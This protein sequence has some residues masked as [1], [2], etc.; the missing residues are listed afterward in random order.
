MNGKKLRWIQHPVV[1]LLA[2]IGVALLLLGIRIVSQKDRFVT[3]EIISS[4]GEWWETLP[5]TPYWLAGSVR[6]GDVE[7]TIGGK[8]LAE[9]LETRK[10]EEDAS[11]ILWA[12]VKLLVTKDQVSNGYK[13]NYQPL[14][15]GSALKIRPHHIQ[16]TGN[17]ISIED[18]GKTDE[19][20]TVRVTVKSYDLYPWFADAIHVGDTA[21]DDEGNITATVV[22]KTTEPAEMA[23]SDSMG[24]ILPSRNPLKRDL[25]LTVDIQV[26]R[27]GGQ[28]YFN[29]IQPVLI[30]TKL[31]IPF[32][33]FELKEA[34]VVAIGNPDG[35]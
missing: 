11:K 13:F 4:G 19:F 5:K 32:P 16:L 24:R 33:T 8:K 14:L 15:I 26:A 21:A 1:V 28:L 17:V 3:V 7:Y 9:V 25:T 12:K 34:S 29:L 27:R 6:P 22:A 2:L 30:G 18:V 23:A 20:K 35:E 10:Y 31:W